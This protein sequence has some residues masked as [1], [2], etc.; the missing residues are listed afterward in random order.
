M[1]AAKTTC[2]INLSG[3]LAFH[4]LQDDDLAQEVALEVWQSRRKYRGDGP[5]HAFVNRIISRKR[6]KL[7]TADIAARAHIPLPDALQPREYKTVML[8]FPTAEAR[9]AFEL[10]AEGYSW[11]EIAGM[12]GISGDAMRQKAQR[13][14]KKITH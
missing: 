11:A 4:R 14:K 6:A 5:F 13:W 12:M 7:V 2:C 10:N 9:R 8:T 1:P 3:L